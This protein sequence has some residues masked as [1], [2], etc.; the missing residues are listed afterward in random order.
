MGKHRSYDFE[1]M[2]AEQLQDDA[3]R[4]E[5]TKL[6]EEFSVAKEVIRLRKE[7]NLTQA[8]LAQRVGTS[9]PAI[10]RLESGNYR[11]LSLSFLGRVAK[12]LNA[13]PEIHLKKMS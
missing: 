5:Y 12:A 3:F 7:Q 1:E 11:R 8:E 4:Q 2:L 13:T 10:A 6:E 9:Q